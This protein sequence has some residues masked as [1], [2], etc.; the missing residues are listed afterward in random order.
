MIVC[1]KKIDNF[2]FIYGNVK[3]HPFFSVEWGGIK[4]GTC[5]PDA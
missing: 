5:S 4:G 3:K 1:Q 2:G